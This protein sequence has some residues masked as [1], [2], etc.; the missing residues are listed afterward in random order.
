MGRWG[1]KSSKFDSSSSQ[2]VN[3]VD[4]DVEMTPP[5]PPPSMAMSTTALSFMSTPT[6]NAKMFSEAR[7]HDYITATSR[8]ELG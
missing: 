7:C 6:F 3:R 1:W 4:R 8:G 2:V 5:A